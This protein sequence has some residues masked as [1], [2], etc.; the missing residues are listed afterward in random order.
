MN[1]SYKGMLDELVMLF[2][3]STN[4]ICVFC[5]TLFLGVNEGFKTHPCWTPVY[6]V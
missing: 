2:N 6:T 4:L 1:E 5:S 3:T